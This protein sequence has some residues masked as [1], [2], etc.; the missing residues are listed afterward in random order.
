MTDGHNVIDLDGIPLE[1][2]LSLVGKAIYGNSAVISL[3]DWR[4]K[5]FHIIYTSTAPQV[6]VSTF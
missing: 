5:G 4:K 2:D 3:H 6:C 1:R